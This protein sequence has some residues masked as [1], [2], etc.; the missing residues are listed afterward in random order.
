MIKKK[1]LEKEEK[2]AQFAREKEPL[3]RELD[4]LKSRN[5]Y[6]EGSYEAVR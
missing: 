4:E 1:L 6:L 2:L 5:T 3:L